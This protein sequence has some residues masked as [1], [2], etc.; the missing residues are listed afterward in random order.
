MKTI[1]CSPGIHNLEKESNKKT[2]D[3]AREEMLRAKSI[4][5]VFESNN[6]ADNLWVPNDNHIINL[7]NKRMVMS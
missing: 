1:L 5:E 6:F 2:K 4:S 3:V 7:L